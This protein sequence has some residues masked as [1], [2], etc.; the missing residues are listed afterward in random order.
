M[1]ALPT[2]TPM[3]EDTPSPVHNAKFYWD[4]EMATFLVSLWL[5]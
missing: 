5:L 2:I 3:D 1:T 4:D